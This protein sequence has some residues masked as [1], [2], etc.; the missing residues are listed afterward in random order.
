MKDIKFV[1]LHAHCGVGSPFDGFGFPADHMDYAHQNG[2]EALALTDHGNMNGMSYQVLH[3][4]KMKAQGKEFR[5]IFGV[6][7]YFVPSVE[8]WKKTYEEHKADKK[9]ARALSKEQSGTNIEAD[10]RREFDFDRNRLFQL[11]NLHNLKALFCG[12]PLQNQ[13]QQRPLHSG[14]DD[15]NLV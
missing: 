12:T 15:R 2:C 5:P 9:K 8:E 10:Q 3:A 6:E 7:A 11:S 13:V 1:G 4:K 14:I